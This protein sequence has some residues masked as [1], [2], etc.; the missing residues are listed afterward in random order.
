[1]TDTPRMVI[2]PAEPDCET[3]RTLRQW[4]EV[5]WKLGA[6]TERDIYS[7]IVSA[8]P[9]AGKIRRAD[10]E[11]ALEAAHK[12]KNLAPILVREKGQKARSISIGELDRIWQDAF[13]AALGLQ[14]AE[15]GDT[16]A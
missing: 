4:R 10:L 8:S 11:R 6:P 7:G 15:K 12:A 14:I 5:G 16:D 2:V 1:M 9:N 3:V 13:A